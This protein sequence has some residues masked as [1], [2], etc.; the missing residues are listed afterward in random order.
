MTLCGQCSW[1]RPLNYYF[2]C[3]TR[4][5]RSKEK[6]MCQLLYFYTTRGIQARRYCAH[7]GQTQNW[8]HRDCSHIDWVGCWLGNYALCWWPRVSSQVCKIDSN[9]A[10]ENTDLAPEDLTEK[11]EE[12][13]KGETTKTLLMRIDV[14]PKVM[15]DVGLLVRSLKAIIHL[16]QEGNWETLQ[17]ANGIRGIAGYLTPLKTHGNFSGAIALG[18]F[19][20]DGSATS[21]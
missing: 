18:L 7:P 3:P 16:L 12:K 21:E 4:W 1:T 6:V 20:S 5:P 10:P 11:K 15:D 19:T 17:N 2:N 9:S 8:R 14:T 13:P